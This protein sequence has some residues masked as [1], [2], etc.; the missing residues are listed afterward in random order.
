MKRSEI[1][2][3]VIDDETE[4]LGH[5]CRLFE[6]EG[7]QVFSAENMAEGIAVF[8]V[9]LPHLCIVD[10]CLTMFSMRESGIDFLREVMKLSQPFK[11]IVVSGR[12]K[13]ETIEE[14]EQMPIDMFMLKPLDTDKLREAVVKILKVEE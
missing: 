5:M 4:V 7:Y 13:P 12:C 8:K 3:L 6:R 14:I 1:K 9:N 10:V 11:S 2:I